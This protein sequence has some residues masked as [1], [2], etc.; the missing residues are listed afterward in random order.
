DRAWQADNEKHDRGQ[1]TGDETAQEIARH[2]TAD[3]AVDVVSDRTPPSLRRWSEQREKRLDPLPALEQHKEGHKGDRDCR[4]HCVDNTSCEGER[5]TRDAE[6]L[7]GA[8]FLQRLPGLVD[9][10]VL[11]LEEAEPAATLRQVV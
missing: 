9:E 5:G 8:A 7:R 10:V 4:E 11:R 6:Q 2:V 1:P 3:S